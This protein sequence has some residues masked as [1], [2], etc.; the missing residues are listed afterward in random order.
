MYLQMIYPIIA[1]F[2]VVSKEKNAHRWQDFWIQNENLIKREEYG[3][4]IEIEAF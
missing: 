1:Y 2:L 4:H 3:E